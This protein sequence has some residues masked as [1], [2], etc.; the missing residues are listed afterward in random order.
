MKLTAERLLEETVR[1]EYLSDTLKHFDMFPEDKNTRENSI[2]ILE[3]KIAKAETE[4][5][6][7]QEE[8]N[9]YREALTI[10]K[11]VSNKYKFRT[12]DPNTRDFEEPEE[13][14]EPEA[15]DEPENVCNPTIAA[16][17]RHINELRKDYKASCICP[18]EGFAEL[19]SDWI[20]SERK[21][22]KRYIELQ[23][24]K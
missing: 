5:K 2:E 20:E 16:C 22:L 9:T 17:N 8:V 10:L 6:E 7:L 4:I 23:E 11:Y 3:S 19:F 14:E 12:S 18:G 21:F 13:L 15:P 24:P 1:N